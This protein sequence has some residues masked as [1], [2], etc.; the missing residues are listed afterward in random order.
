LHHPAPP[1]VLLTRA[2]NPSTPLK[3]Y[4]RFQADQRL[5]RIDREASEYS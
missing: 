4:A 3:Y 5:R 2:P 1:R